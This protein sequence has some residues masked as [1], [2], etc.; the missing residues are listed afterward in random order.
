MDN[1]QLSTLLENEKKIYN[2]TN[3]QPNI[4]PENNRYRD[5]IKKTNIQVFEMNNN[6]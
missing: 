1:L 2:P 6:L 5:M 4:L 3:I